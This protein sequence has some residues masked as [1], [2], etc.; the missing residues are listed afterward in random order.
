[1][2]KYI[3]SFTFQVTSFVREKEKTMT[4][5]VAALL[6]TFRCKYE[7]I[8]PFFFSLFLHIHL[9]TKKNRWV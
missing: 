8:L 1:M 2:K 6:C 3:C 7:C 4:V 5:I 9:R